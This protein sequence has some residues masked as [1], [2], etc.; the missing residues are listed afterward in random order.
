MEAEVV[1][2]VFTQRKDGKTLQAIADFLNYNNTPTKRGGKW[3]KVHIK[4]MLERVE[5]YKGK[6]KHGNVITDGQHEAI[7]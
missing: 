7:L 2:K 4:D 3:S 5:I 6:Y 1:R